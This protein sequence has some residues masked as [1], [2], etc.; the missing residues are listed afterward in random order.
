MAEAVPE[1]PAKRP[2]AKRP[3]CIHDSDKYQ[4][5]ICNDCGHGHHWS[6]CKVRNSCPHR[7][8]S[9]N[10]DLEIP[11][12]FVC[13]TQCMICHPWLKT[14][15]IKRAMECPHGKLSANCI[16]CAGCEHGKFRTNWCGICI[17]T[18]LHLPFGMAI[19]Q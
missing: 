11:A 8:I 6:N 14:A 3:R 1:P 10:P 13:K 18:G 9:A 4:R 15:A 5:G 12:H 19:R 17:E 16:L 7:T 2:C